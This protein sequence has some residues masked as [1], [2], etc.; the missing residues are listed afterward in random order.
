MH[1]LRLLS[2]LFLT[3]AIL[4]AGNGLQGTMIALRG[5]QE[6]FSTFQIGLMGAAYF[7]GFMVGCLSITHMLCAVGHIRVFSALAAVSASMALLLFMVIDPYAWLIFRF[8]TGFCFVGLF[9]TVESWIN[10]K[11]DSANRGRILSIYRLI[12][13]GAV[14]ASQ[15]LLPI[16]G[17][18][19]FTLFG[20]MAMMITLSLV[21][22]SLADRSNPGVPASFKFSVSYIWKLSPIACLGCVTIGLTTAAFRLV[23]PIYAKSI[24]LEL[25]GVAAFMSAGI[26]GGIMLQYPLG[27][28]SDRFDRRIILIL[29]TVGASI[30]GIFISLFA[31]ISAELNYLGIFLFGAFA[32]P[33]YSLSAAHANDHAQNDGFAQVAAGLMFF[34][35]AGAIIG[36]A[37]AS[38]LMQQFGPQFLFIY[39]SVIH[40]G[41]IVAAVWRMKIRTSVPKSRRSRF[42]IHLRTSPILNKMGLRAGKDKTPPN[43]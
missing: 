37:L 41:L 16:F 10:S 19:G 40:T 25:S 5:A 22:I 4:L 24:G 26:I 28:L 18:G 27:Y 13:L 2:P 7:S 17:L 30:S 35:S 33:L 29:A 8:V 20:I 34:W 38:L 23:G 15:Y 32:L 12:D 43:S 31:H 9:S 3:A 14:T 36:P 39:T 42:V 21:P 1:V 6:G 11:V